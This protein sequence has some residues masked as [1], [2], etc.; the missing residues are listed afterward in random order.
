MRA[1]L[2][3][4]DHDTPELSAVAREL[5]AALGATALAYKR[6]D[7]SM[8]ARTLAYNA[9]NATENSATNWAKVLQY[10]NAGIST[11]ATPFDL[12]I[13]GDGGNSWY[14]LLKG[15]AE[16]TSWLRVD[17][18]IIQEADPSQPV[19]YSSTTP[20]PFPAIA[21][22]RFASGAKDANGDIRTKGKDFWFINTVPYD[23]ARGVYFFSQ[24][25][26][27]RY[28][29]HGYE[30]DAAFLTL[31]PYVLAAE[32]DLLIAEALVRTGGDLT[33]A[34]SL[35]STLWCAW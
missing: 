17:Q 2:P 4:V 31:V 3:L 5:D 15:Y 14:D 21:D 34:A 11:G 16:L 28:V 24:W 18:R 19:E 12:Q 1:L 30:M 7:A 10:A 33:R 26:H 25:A 6:L 35:M 23:P 29:D 27:A 20:P 13:Q 9:R 22:Q 32:N 8:A